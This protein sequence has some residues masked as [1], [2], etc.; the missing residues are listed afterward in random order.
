MT[1]RV[2]VTGIGLMT[3][4]GTT[5]DQVW[6][7]LVAGRTI[8]RTRLVQLDPRYFASET[9]AAYLLRLSEPEADLRRRVVAIRR[10]P[11][12]TGKPL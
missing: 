12:R 1:R 11:R 9:L 3:A 2:V 10:R 8:G 4:L 7:G 5:R 6:D